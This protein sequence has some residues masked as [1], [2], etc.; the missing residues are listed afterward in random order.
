MK[1][2]HIA[3]IKKSI[4][5]SSICLAACYSVVRNIPDWRITGKWIGTIIFV[6]I[7]IVVISVHKL[8]KPEYRFI[9]DIRVYSIILIAVNLG[10]AGICLLQITGVIRNDSLFNA[11]ADFDNPAGIASSLCC[12]FP[13]SLMLSHQKKISTIL[14]IIIYSI[15]GLFLFLIQS[16]TGLMALGTSGLFLLLYTLKGLKTR[17][18]WLYLLFLLFLI[19]TFSVFFLFRNK[20]ASTNGRKVIYNTCVRMI[21]DRPILGYGPDGFG[22]Y[23]MHWQADYLKTINDQNIIMLSDNITHPLSELLLITVN[24]GLVGLFVVVGLIVYTVVLSQKREE[25]IRTLLFMFLCN[26]CILSLFSYPFRYPMTT[27]ALIFFVSILFKDRLEMSKRDHNRFISIIILIISILS[28][29]FVVRWY[30]AQVYWK[31]M[32]EVFNSCNEFKED[33]LHLTDKML[34]NN[35]RYLYSR[36]VVNFYAGDYNSSLTYAEK[37]AEKLSSYDSEL[38]I[39]NI[40]QKLESNMDAEIHYR[41]AS[42]MCPSKITPLYRLFR[43]YD[44]ERDTVKMIKIGHE[45]LDMP[46]KVSSHDTR[47]MRFDVRR[48]L[49]FL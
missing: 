8:V 46:V 25:H 18:K 45:I 28:F 14:A 21:A 12:T 16:R 1:T 24:Y 10:I 33:Y 11:V 19:E 26:I 5:F 39:G 3:F 35:P 48:K 34:G 17:T 2:A 36:A 27:I 7:S 40:L 32:I 37:S 47:A 22:K 13:F 31:E 6:L 4:L 9:P 20:V 41:E 43:L 29:L 49:L 42:N 15:D 44:E 38:L 23:Y 30:K